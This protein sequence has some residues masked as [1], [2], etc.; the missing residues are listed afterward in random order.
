MTR[1]QW[2]A[3]NDA[4]HARLA[5]VES[6]LDKAAPA[7]GLAKIATADDPRAVWKSLSVAQRRKIIDTLLVVRLHSP[8]RGTRTFRPETVEVTPK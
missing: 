6:H 2:T 3:A 5:E 4:V 7:P 1:D 8:G